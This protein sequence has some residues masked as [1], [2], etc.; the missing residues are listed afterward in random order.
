MQSSLRMARTPMRPSCLERINPS[1]ESYPD[2]YRRSVKRD[3][4]TPTGRW[5]IDG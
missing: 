2:F 3:L 1:T 5:L 4:T